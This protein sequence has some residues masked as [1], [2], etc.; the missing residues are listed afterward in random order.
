MYNRRERMRQEYVARINRVMDYIGA[1]LNGDL[2]LEKLAGVAN[3][4][5]YHFH[6]IFRGMTGETLRQP[7]DHRGV[8]ASFECLYHRTQG[9]TC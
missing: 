9:H 3:F 8:E 4:S 5:P 6:R 1:N 7:R 2:C